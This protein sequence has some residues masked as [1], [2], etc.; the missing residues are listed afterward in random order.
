MNKEEYDFNEFM[1]KFQHKI[2][3]LQKDF[4]NLS[5]NNKAK[6][7]NLLNQYMTISGITE[8]INILGNFKNQ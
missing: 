3:E 1:I 4:N 8:F 7:F 5:D 2:D 6:V